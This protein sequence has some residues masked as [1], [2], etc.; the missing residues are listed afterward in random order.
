ME[1]ALIVRKEWSDKIFDEFDPKLWE[2]RS[3]KTK[4]RGTIGIIEAGSGLIVGSVEIETC[5][6]DKIAPIEKFIKYHKVKDLSLLEKWCYA[7]VLSNAKRFDEPIPYKHPK[8]AVIWVK[9]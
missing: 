8:G 9:M 7:W 1:R 3:F 6:H 5:Y 4:V 2:M